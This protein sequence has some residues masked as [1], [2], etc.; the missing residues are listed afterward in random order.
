MDEQLAAQQ[1]EVEEARQ[2]VLDSFQ[3][4]SVPDN[5]ASLPPDKGLDDMGLREYWPYFDAMQNLHVTRALNDAMFAR[6]QEARIADMSLPDLEKAHV[7]LARQIEDDDQAIEQ[8][9]LELAVP[10]EV[11]RV[12]PNQ[13]LTQITLKEYWRFFDEIQIRSR[14]REIMNAMRARLAHERFE[15]RVT[16]E[17]ESR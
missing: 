8:L 9:Y 6:A 12:S 10:D 14:N 7:E 3:Q 1:L 5:I 13:A 2:R 17:T 16:A 15:A 4:L 11:S